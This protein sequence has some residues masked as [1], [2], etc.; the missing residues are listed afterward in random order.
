MTAEK[1]HKLL[2][3]WQSNETKA[4]RNYSSQW[5]RRIFISNSKGQTL[6]QEREC[7]EGGRGILGVY[8]GI[9]NEEASEAAGGYMS[10]FS[11]S[12]LGLFAHLRQ[13]ILVNRLPQ[14]KY[15]LS[16]AR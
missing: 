13:P 10:D 16:V 8:I 9:G 12:F 1:S 7:V 2:K 14:K 15:F 3:I 11:P 4:E 5:M 6:S